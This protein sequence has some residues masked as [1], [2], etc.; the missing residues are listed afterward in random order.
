MANKPTLT[1][2]PSTM[3]GVS[4]IAAKIF[5]NVSL[6]FGSIAPSSAPKDP[7]VEATPFNS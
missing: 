1:I 4:A 5:G 2:D 3:S 6:P 7:A